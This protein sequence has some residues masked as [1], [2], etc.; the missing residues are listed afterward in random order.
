MIPFTIQG[1]SSEGCLILVELVLYPDL[2][3]V[4]AINDIILSINGRKVSGMLLRDVRKLLEGLFA[5]NESFYMEI[6]SENSIPSSIAEI[7]AGEDYSELQIVIR[8]NVYQK[9][10]PYTTRQPRNGEI[11][12]VHYKFVDVATFRQLRDSNQLLEHGRYQGFKLSH[13]VDFEFLFSFENICE[14][15]NED[16]RWEMT[17]YSSSYFIFNLFR[18]EFDQDV[19]SEISPEETDEKKKK[20]TNFFIPITTS[21]TTC[22]FRKCYSS[23][24][25]IVAERR[26]RIAK[27]RLDWFT[28]E[29]EDCFH[30]NYSLIDYVKTW[31]GKCT[32]N[33]NAILIG[34]NDEFDDPSNSS[35]LR[36]RATLKIGYDCEKAKI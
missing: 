25:D 31:Y 23:H 6:V 5:I 34:T 28:E 15:G 11:D 26:C 33:K 32:R 36:L 7:L 17:Q 18:K 22:L 27:N 4:L 30:L 12:G 24:V 10:V 19:H 21:R 20:I 35:F 16:I 13:A 8:N 29:S 3:N 1:G 14:K 9:T 2:L